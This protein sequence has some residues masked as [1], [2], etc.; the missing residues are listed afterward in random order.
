LFQN[1]FVYYNEEVGE[2]LLRNLINDINEI[3]KVTKIKPQTI[4]IYVSPNWK[5]EIF[6]T[7]IIKAEQE[8]LQIGEMIKDVM[9]NPDLRS[10][11]K[12]I[13]TFIK[14]LPSEIKKLHD[15]DKK[16]YQTMLDERQ[17]LS[18]EISFIEK[19]FHC[20][21]KIFSADDMNRDDP[22]NKARFAQPLK[23]A[24]YIK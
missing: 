10:Q 20:T 2:Y 9:K 6:S 4:Y 7:A 14:K 11:A 12:D 1:D 3:L 23:P 19:S 21:I 22:E 5:N 18:D 24:I 8:S 15:H 17:Y 16:R 13:T